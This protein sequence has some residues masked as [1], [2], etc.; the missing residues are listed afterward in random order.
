[1]T[2]PLPIG[3]NGKMKALLAKTAP[4]PAPREPFMQLF[5]R[6]LRVR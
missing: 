2:K 1:M 3:R 6:V 5:L 4:K